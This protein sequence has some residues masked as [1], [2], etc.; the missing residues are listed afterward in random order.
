V[1][2]LKLL[3]DTHCWIWLTGDWSQLPTPVRRRLNRDPEALVLSVVSVIEISIKLATGR[4]R[5]D[6]GPDRLVAELIAD[7]VSSLG[8][9]IDHALRMATLPLHHRDP[10]DRLLVAQ[11]QIEGFTLVSADPKVLSY[12]VPTIDARK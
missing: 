9:T 2:L 11:A 10:F 8:V 3:L 4:L 5:L 7:G 6:V 1:G 12:D